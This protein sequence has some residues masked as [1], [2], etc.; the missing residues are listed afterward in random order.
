MENKRKFKVKSIKSKKSSAFEWW[1]MLISLF[2]GLA[3]LCIIPTFAG[4]MF[5]TF[6]EEFPKIINQI[7]TVFFFLDHL[8]FLLFFAALIG[9]IIFRKSNLSQ[10]I[11]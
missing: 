8:W 4:S 10:W 6:A 5:G 2:G 7:E 9:F 3:G 1:T 11:S